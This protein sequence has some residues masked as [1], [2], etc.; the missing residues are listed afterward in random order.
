LKAE[1]AW[2]LTEEVRRAEPETEPLLTCWGKSGVFS[3]L[4]VLSFLIQSSGPTLSDSLEEQHRCGE[5]MLGEYK[6]ICPLGRRTSY[7]VREGEA[8]SREEAGERWKGESGAV[9]P[10]RNSGKAKSSRSLQRFQDY[11]GS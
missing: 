3:E 7:E 6:G 9:P 10:P 5:T 4:T 11:F 8:V 2:F 1:R